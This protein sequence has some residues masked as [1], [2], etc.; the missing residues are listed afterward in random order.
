[1]PA[2]PLSRLP[3]AITASLAAG[4]LTLA[5][6][7][8]AG[9]APYNVETSR[10]CDCGARVGSGPPGQL[11]M[12]ANDVAARGQKASTAEPA[13]GQPTWPLHPRPLHSTSSQQVASSAGNDFHW[14]DAGIGAAGALGVMLA[15]LGGS[16]VLRRRHALGS[17]TAA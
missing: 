10:H 6:T 4:A 2:R 8:S 11:S 17:T 3:R 7:A 14:D 9:A 15:G 13:P 1:M 16:L 12:R 5:A